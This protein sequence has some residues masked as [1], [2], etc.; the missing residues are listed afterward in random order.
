MANWVDKHPDRERDWSDRGNKMR[1]H[2]HH[3]GHHHFHNHDWWRGRSLIGFYGPGYG[4]WG[5][6]PWLGYR[7][8]GFWWGRPSWNYVC[9]WFPGY[10]WTDP[11]YY[12]YG[13]GGNV[14]YYD[15]Y[16]AVNG[17][18]VGTPV[19]YAAS[20]FALA[21]VDPAL[22]DPDDRDW[23][24]LGTFSM[25]VRADETE[26]DRVIQ[27]AVNKA[28][29]ISGTVVNEK[30][31]NV[32]A[33]Q[34]RVD[35]DT[36]RVAFTIGKDRDVAFET[37]L[38]NLTR[39]ETPLLVHYGAGQRATYFLARLPEPDQDPTISTA[40]QPAIVPEVAR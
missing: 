36:Q 27:L 17:Q 1:D 23:M 30:S 3:H 40:E 10:G 6:Q 33:V 32:Y 38:A 9:D 25:A 18:N 4:W 20:A 8:F 34:G 11:Y 28:G 26:P 37:G 14:V 29:I 19:D 13:V 5:Y 21:E 15:T 31:G 22:I 2:H 7:P 35:Q 39:N 16:V 12:D 24:P